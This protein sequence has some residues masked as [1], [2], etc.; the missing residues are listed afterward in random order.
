MLSTLLKWWLVGLVTAAT[1]VVNE[2]AEGRDLLFY[3]A[4]TGRFYLQT[5]YVACEPKSGYVNS[6][7]TLRGCW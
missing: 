6:S 5:V 4:E 7:T 1:E 2:P 3:V